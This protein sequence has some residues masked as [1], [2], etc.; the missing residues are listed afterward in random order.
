MV[1]SGCER[2][3]CQCKWLWKCDLHI[4][5]RKE[6]VKV[7]CIAYPEEFLVSQQIPG[8]P[9]ELPHSWAGNLPVSGNK[10]E[11]KELFF[12]LWGPTGSV[13]HDDVVIW[14][15]GGPGCSSLDGIFEENGPFKFPQGQNTLVPNPYSW[16]NLSYVVWIDN[17]VGVG[18]TEGTPDIK[19]QEGLAKEFYG[20]LEQFF[21]TFKELQGKRLWITGESYAGKYIPYIANEVYS[22]SKG[23]S[24]INLQGIAINDPSFTTNWLGEEAPVFEFF[25]QYHKVMGVDSNSVEQLRQEAKSLGVENYVSDNLHFPP[26]GHLKV[27]SSWNN[28]KSIWQSVYMTVQKSNKCFSIYDIKP[29]CDFRTDALGQPLT[30]QQSSKHNF[31]NDTPGFKKAIHAD[32]DIQWQECVDKKV[33]VGR[34]VDISPAPD[35]SVLPGVIEKSKRTVIQHGTYDMVLIANGTALAIQNMTWNNQMGFQRKPN[36]PVKLDG[37]VRGV[38]TEERGLTYVQVDG[39]GHMIPQFKPKVAY[40]LQRYL[41][42]QVD[43]HEL[44][45]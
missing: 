36:T 35:R 23:A 22:H 34:D 45:S 21:S 19:G 43:A 40:Q 2:S 16:T 41:L 17:P 18:F 31:I 8:V 20:F 37:K 7:T 15:N 28:T 4:T 38:M 12:W 44:S 10:G 30:S 6:Y 27:P 11:N 14:L 32:E 39:S 5:C 24:G 33:F 25:E 26:R 1:P 29:D 9:F 13:G 3:L 42:G